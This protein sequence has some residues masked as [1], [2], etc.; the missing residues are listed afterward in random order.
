MPRQAHPIEDA[1]PFG[2]PFE[3]ATLGPFAEDDELVLRI[4]DAREGVQQQRKVLLRRE[5]ADGEE[6]AAGARLLGAVAKRGEAVDLGKRQA[7]ILDRCD[8][9]PIGAGRPCDLRLHGWRQRHEGIEQAPL[10]P[11]PQAVERPD[12]ARQIAAIEVVA[13]LGEDRRALPPEDQPQGGRDHRIGIAG[14]KQ[15]VRPLADH[16]AGQVGDHPQCL[17][18]AGRKR[19]ALEDLDPAGEAIRRRR[20]FGP[21]QRHGRDETRAG[22]GIREPEGDPLDS[23][24]FEAVEENHHLEHR[25]GLSLGQRCRGFSPPASMRSR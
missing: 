24:R 10:R 11:Q 12:G 13:D 4:G 1:E 9:A 18:P 5:P 15:D 8:A 19:R 20:A 6:P 16:Q 17:E 7:G 14:A 22:P 3:P 2:Q 23:A 25:A 21:P